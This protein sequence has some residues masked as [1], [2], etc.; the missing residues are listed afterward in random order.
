MSSCQLYSKAEMLPACQT[1]HT[2]Q[3]CMP[4]SL[5]APKAHS[6]LPCHVQVS[7]TTSATSAAKVPRLLE[8]LRCSLPPVAPFKQLPQGEACKAMRGSFLALISAKSCTPCCWLL[9][10][11][12]AGLVDS[13]SHLAQSCWSLSLLQFRLHCPASPL[14]AL[15]TGPCFL[16]CPAAM[17]NRS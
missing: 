11:Q 9:A 15:V 5:P 10:V 2:T 14:A 3:G 6:L 17:S 7:D 4:F 13:F 1:H 12:H 8:V 16:P